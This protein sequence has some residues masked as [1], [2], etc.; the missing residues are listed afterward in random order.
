MGQ[1][2]LEGNADV[3]GNGK[4]CLHSTIR[5]TSVAS[6]QYSV[7]LLN[8][9]AVNVQCDADGAQERG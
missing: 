3:G 2:R 8:A 6:E 1:R 4:P 7:S 9:V 5:G